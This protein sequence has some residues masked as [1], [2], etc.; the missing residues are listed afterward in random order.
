[1]K[2]LVV[3]V[4]NALFFSLLA[5]NLSATSVTNTNDSGAGSLRQTLTD[6]LA[7]TAS[8]PVDFTPG[9]TGTINLASALPTINTN[10]TINGPG[11]AVI[12]VRRSSGG[13]YRIFNVNAGTVSISGLTIANGNPGATSG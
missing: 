10:I 4:V 13:S 2:R 11:A 6:V 7:G 5:Q 3:I 9:V 1:M 8:G 12:T